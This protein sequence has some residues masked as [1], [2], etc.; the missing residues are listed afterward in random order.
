MKNG[1][2][3]VNGLWTSLEAH[4]GSCWSI[5]EF[6]HFFS[7]PNSWRSVEISSIQHFLGVFG[8][9]GTTSGGR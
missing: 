9:F 6:P 7:T 4:R 3:S 1:R 2:A 5:V 8:I